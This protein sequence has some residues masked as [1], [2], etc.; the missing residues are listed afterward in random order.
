M[1][2]AW[3]WTGMVA[4]S[5]VYGLF[6]GTIGAVGNAALEGAAAAVELC[7]SMAGVMCLWS[8]VMSIMKASGLMDGLSRLF[9]PVLARLLPHACQDPDTLAALS[10]NVSANLLG[11]GNAATP[12]GIQAARRMARHTGGQASDEL[13][14]LV[15]LNTASIQLLPTT[16]GGVRAALGAQSAF[17]ILPAVWMASVLSVAAGL[18]AAKIFAKLWR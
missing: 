4:L 16:L 2:M 17:D 1:A 10:G 13:C 7:L 8:G 6:N 14:T 11:L 12:L 15:V 9:R 3:I 5:V 18:L